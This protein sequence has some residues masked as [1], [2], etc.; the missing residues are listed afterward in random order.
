MNKA[1]ILALRKACWR[2]GIETRK[3]TDQRT[4]EFTN[5]PALKVP[6]KSAVRRSSNEARKAHRRTAQKASM[7]QSGHVKFM[8][9]VIARD[10]N[11]QKLFAAHFRRKDAGWLHG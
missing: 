8:S 7:M 3:T 11:T 1:T 4:A 10:A 5:M 9:P 2:L 6:Y